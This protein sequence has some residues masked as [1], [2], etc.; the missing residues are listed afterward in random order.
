[1]HGGLVESSKNGGPVGDFLTRGIIFFYL[2]RSG[3]GLSEQDR[4]LRSPFRMLLRFLFEK[5]LQEA[6]WADPVRE[7]LNICCSLQPTGHNVAICEF[8]YLAQK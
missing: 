8:L 3:K 7:G 4:L 2:L 1:M 6:R 5:L